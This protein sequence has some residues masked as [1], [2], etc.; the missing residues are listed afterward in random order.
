MGLIYNYNVIYRSQIFYRIAIL[1]ISRN[2][3]APPT[4]ES[5]F[6]VG[7]QLCYKMTRLKLDRV[8]A[9]HLNN[10]SHTDFL[11]KLNS[12]SYNQSVSSLL[13]L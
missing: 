7:L 5:F 12:C 10:L 4:M 1:K 6:R 13:N 9:I 3:Q 11:Q 2:S 8:F